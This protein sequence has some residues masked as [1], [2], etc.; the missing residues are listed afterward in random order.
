MDKKTDTEMQNGQCHYKNEHV[1]VW[2]F[3][4][5]GRKAP[6]KV[7]VPSN[8]EEQRKQMPA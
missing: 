1:V 6:E 5:R 4:H 3:R 8:L 7:T 2:G